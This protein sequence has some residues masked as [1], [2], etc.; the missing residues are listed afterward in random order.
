M[1]RG[2]FEYQGQKCSA[3][4]RAYLPKNQWDEIKEN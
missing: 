3:M 4:S 1:I 2:A